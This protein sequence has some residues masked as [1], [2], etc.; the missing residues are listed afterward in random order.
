MSGAVLHRVQDI[1]LAVL[2]AATAVAELWVPFVS[3][4]GEG[5]REV[6]TAVVLLGCGMLSL[7]R[8][9]PLLTIAVI[10]ALW[11]IVF[12]ITP[13]PT[14]FW[15]QFAPF[16]LAVYSVA[17]HGQGRR[18]LY[19]AAIA[20]A[21]LLFLDL[22]VDLL[23]TPEEIV[24]HWTLTTLTW[25]AGWGLRSFERRAEAAARRA[26]EVE[27]ESRTRTL[28]AIAEE[29]ARIAR[30]LHDIVAHSVSVMVV[31]AGAA[32]QVVD[33]DPAFVRSALGTI[34]STGTGALGEMRRVVSMLREPGEPDAGALTPQPGIG[35]LSELVAAARTTGTQVDLDIVGDTTGLPIGVDLAAFRIVQEALTN[36]RKHSGAS[37]VRV[38]V[39]RT[40]NRLDV[41]VADDGEAGAG[42]LTST[43]SGHG[44]I[45][46]RERVE[47]Y[48]GS[49]DAGPLPGAGFRVHAS[50][51]VTEPT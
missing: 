3:V 1:A 21:M 20:A 5:S 15:G 28:T 16:L 2:L 30:E 42:T 34:R 37:H 10:A 14:L 26:A 45:G 47:L 32:E 43:G 51:P 12:T 19:G 36:V 23:A 25:F 6:A 48:G 35:A 22:R 24:F 44:L 38:A 46:M 50:L 27:L 39:T 40:G 4:Q 9:R 18:G 8:V 11:P 41:E 13:I 7:R 29:R 49:L 17:R 31:Q 33:D